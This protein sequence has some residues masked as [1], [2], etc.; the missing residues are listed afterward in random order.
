[1]K[2]LGLCKSQF[3]FPFLCTEARTSVTVTPQDFQLHP[4]RC[5]SDCAKT[6]TCLVYMC[7]HML[8]VVALPIH[9]RMG[10]GGVSWAGAW[11]F[12]TKAVD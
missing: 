10:W 6:R 12:L 9:G 4:E 8:A 11:P 2:V 1:M 3:P 5:D 7:T